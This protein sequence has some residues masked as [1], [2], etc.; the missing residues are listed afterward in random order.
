MLTERPSIILITGIMASGKS[1]VAQL[2]SE[3]FEKSV[4]LRGDIF[5]RMI[6]NNRK[7]VHPDA[8]SDELNQLRL[9][10]RLAAQS[11]DAYFQVGFT[12]V[13]Q[14]VVIGPMLN[15]FISYIQSRPFYVVVLC[16]N[17]S[18]VILRE[19][20]RIKKGYGVWTVEGLD[21][22]LRNETPRI[23]MWLDSSELTPDET[24]N[25]SFFV[26]LSNGSRA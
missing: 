20:A 24:V 3:R 5:R 16:P 13:V 19:S 22:L 2:L 15:D 7:E 4:H 11:A 8:G 18:V 23:G 14:D 21:S 10:Y 9:R 17:S 6:V 1:T 25:V 26:H 12:V